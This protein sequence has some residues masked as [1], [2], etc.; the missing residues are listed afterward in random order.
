MTMKD[1]GFHTGTIVRHFKG[2]MYKIIAR[3]IHTE[4]KEPYVVYERLY[5]PFD[6]FARP[7]EMFCSKTDKEKYPNAKQEWRMEEWDGNV[8][9]IKDGYQI[10]D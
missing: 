7:E 4:T 6:S 9:N 5:P 8:D 10:K 3:A 1:R 2:G